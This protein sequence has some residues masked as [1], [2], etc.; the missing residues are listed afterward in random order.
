M[1]E[2]LLGH[3]STPPS[4]SQ[5]KRVPVASHANAALDRSLRAADSSDQTFSH[6]CIEPASTAAPERVAGI[7][8]QKGTP[9][10]TTTYS[11]PSNGTRNRE[12]PNS[13]GTADDISSK[14]D[15]LSAWMEAQGSS[16]AAC[17]FVEEASSLMPQTRA[18]SGGDTRVMRH[19]FPGEQ[20]VDAVQAPSPGNRQ[21]DG[22]R[23]FGNKSTVVAQS[24]DNS[25]GRDDAVHQLRELQHL[26]ERVR[27]K[28]AKLAAIDPKTSQQ[29]VRG[30]A[31]VLTC[32]VLRMYWYERHGRV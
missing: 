26:D 6:H 4:S 30:M 7:A 1:R 21:L 22:A 27:Q 25:S 23:G 15:H 28:L 12:T 24:F 17:A 11:I 20:A 18:H 29:Q 10:T 5:Q 32:W 8:A 16:G 9:P 19:L 3:V 13:S 2:T 14:V 31:A